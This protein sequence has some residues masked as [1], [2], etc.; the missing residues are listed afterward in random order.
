MYQSRLLRIFRDVLGHAQRCAS[1]LKTICTL[2]AFCAGSA[3][4][5]RRVFSN[6]EEDFAAHFVRLIGCEVISRNLR[7]H[8]AEVDLLCRRRDSEEYFFFEV[9][10][11]RK[12][13]NAFY[14]PVSQAQLR[15]LVDAAPEHNTAT[16]A[17]HDAG[18]LR[19]GG[20]G[21]MQ[22]KFV[23]AAPGRVLPPGLFTSAE[24]PLL[25]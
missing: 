23:G 10:K 2:R 20:A 3:A 21:R 17:S 1:K 19:S 25:A 8:G 15:R 16:L 18:V 11:S 9:K 6:S 14:P 7:R 24:A 4:A 12:A 13:A 5:I 22:M